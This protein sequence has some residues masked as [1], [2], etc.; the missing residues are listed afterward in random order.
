MR[1]DHVLPEPITIGSITG[2]DL[3]REIED[4]LQRALR[5]GAEP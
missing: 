3:L 1:R 4:W 5:L 2:W